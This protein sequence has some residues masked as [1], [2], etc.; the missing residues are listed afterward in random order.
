MFE[1]FRDIYLESQGIDCLAAE[2]I[3]NE[4]KEIKR[5]ERYLFTKKMKALVIVL[6]IIYLAIAGGNLYALKGSSD[7][8]LVYLRYGGLSAL[9][10]AICMA[11]IFGKKKGEIVAIIGIF[12]FILINYL[13]VFI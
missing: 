5:L 7:M 13:A 10:I 1:Y 3:R 8:W 6:G 4:K 9:D 11:L 2:K 12:I